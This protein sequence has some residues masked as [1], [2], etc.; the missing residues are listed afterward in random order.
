[1]YVVSSGINSQTPQTPGF[2]KCQQP[3]KF[4]KKQLSHNLPF[5]HLSLLRTRVH[6]YGGFVKA[7]TITFITPVDIAK[8]SQLNDLFEFCQVRQTT[9]YMSTSIIPYPF[10]NSTQTFLCY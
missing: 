3:Y 1:M 8:I 4:E 5:F 7:M 2:A 6:S 10:N 9:V